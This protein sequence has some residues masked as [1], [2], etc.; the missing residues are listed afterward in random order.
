MYV[1]NFNVGQFIYSVQDQLHNLQGLGQ[2][3]NVGSYIQKLVKIS[4]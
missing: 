1:P 2:N 4:R 3:Q